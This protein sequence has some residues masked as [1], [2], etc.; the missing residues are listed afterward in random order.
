MRWIPIL[1]LASLAGEATLSAQQVRVLGEIDFKGEILEDKDVSAI[2]LLGDQ[3][4][5]G[6]DEGAIIQL[7]R[8]DADR[9]R[10]AR[11]LALR[12]DDKEVDIEGIATEQE[13]VYVMGSHSRRRIVLDD[14]AIR[15]G[16]Q[17]R[18]GSIERQESREQLYRFRIAADGKTSDLA[19]T[20]LT[21]L[22][23]TD[24]VLR[25][26]V[27]LPS[28]ENGIDIEGIAARDGWL[29]IGFRGPVL[30]GNLTP[31]LKCR[32]GDPV[33]DAEWLFVDL[34]GNGVRDLARTSNGFLILAGPVGD[35]KGSYPLYV[36][37]GT[38]CFLAIQAGND[39]E[40][41]RKLLGEIPTSKGD[42][43]EGLALLREDDSS[44]EVLV[45]YDG[46]KDGRP[47]R[48][49]VGKTPVGNQN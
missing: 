13:T 38:D 39:R 26:F 18:I 15:Q 45:V 30:R 28:K 20:S 10:V 23:A 29:Y 47:T 31:I 34:D 24:R 6:A 5:I 43:A 9:Y 7:L 37:D 21:P 35:R 11:N 32:F 8:R 41:N 25:S 33:T 22:L 27:A 14:E 44:Y 36:W 3:L 40:S 49:L 2:A 42:K 16:A 17:D 46:A 4:L 19:S 12:G 48:M 1:I